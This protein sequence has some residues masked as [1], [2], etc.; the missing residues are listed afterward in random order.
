[1]KKG[2]PYI[3][4]TSV[5]LFSLFPDVSDPIPSGILRLFIELLSSPQHKATYARYYECWM[6]HLY[7]WR[8]PCSKNARTKIAY[9]LWPAI[10]LNSGE[11]GFFPDMYRVFHSYICFRGQGYKWRYMR[12]CL[13]FQHS[14][15]GNSFLRWSS[16]LTDFTE[17]ETI[18]WDYQGSFFPI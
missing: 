3:S 16:Y 7:S 9:V 15:D 14:R 18:D 5:H 6:K 4:L 17:L 8:N 10:V 2:P 1:M 11:T 13:D 12:G